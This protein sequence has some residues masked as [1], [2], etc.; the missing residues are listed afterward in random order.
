M[1]KNKSLKPLWILVLVPALLLIAAGAAYGAD[2]TAI[3]DAAPFIEKGVTYDTVRPIAETFG[4]Y[5]DWDQEG[6]KV[7]LTRG[8]RQVIMAV[9]DANLV[10]ATPEGEEEVLA[11]DTPPVLIG[12][13]VFLPTRLWAETFGLKVEWEPEDGRVTVSE[14]KKALTFAP[15]SK[16]FTLTGGHFLKVYDQDESLR[17]YYPET[18]QPDIC[19]EGYAEVILNIEGDDYVISAINAGAGRSDPV[20]YSVEEIDKLIIRNAEIDQLSAQKLPDVY[21]GAPAYRISGIVSGISQ[22]GVIFLKDSLLCGLTVEVMRSS[23]IEVIQ[24]NELDE[25]LSVGME[26]TLIHDLDDLPESELV[27][28]D[29]EKLESQLAIVNSL[30]DEIMASFTVS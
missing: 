24:G 5:I 6:Q 12:G 16:E 14:G 26:G 28:Y 10:L 9:G 18:G 13:R 25:I 23:D 30:L 3:M 11:V 1:K 17:F 29:R 8:A 15:G 22:A 2:A 20:R 27:R 21:Y 4:I 7:T 19:W